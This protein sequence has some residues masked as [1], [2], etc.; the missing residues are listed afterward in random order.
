MHV[1]GCLTSVEGDGLIHMN[2]NREVKHPLRIALFL[3]TTQRRMVIFY[4]RFG[5]TSVKDYHSTLRNT[6]EERRSQQHRGG[7]LK[8]RKAPTD[9]FNSRS[10]FC[11][12]TGNYPL[13]PTPHTWTSCKSFTSCIHNLFYKPCVL[14]RK[15]VTVLWSETNLGLTNFVLAHMTHTMSISGC[16]L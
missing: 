3:G 6:P 11:L 9:R 8:S 12:S 15:H 16:I 10:L 14:N 1:V 4:R 7:S 5:T 2:H 13:I